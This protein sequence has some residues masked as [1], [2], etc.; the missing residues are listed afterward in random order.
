MELDTERESPT[1]N[2]GIIRIR[3][4]PERAMILPERRPMPRIR[5]PVSRV[6]T[7][8]ENPLHQ[9]ISRPP[10]AMPIPSVVCRIA[11]SSGPSL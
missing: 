10:G 7:L 11:R 5:S 9:L 6:V 4:E 2:R 1:I 3:E 8:L